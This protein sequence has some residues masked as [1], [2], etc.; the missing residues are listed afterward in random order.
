MNTPDQTVTY[1]ESTHKIRG[2]GEGRGTTINTAL[3]I[4]HTVEAYRMGINMP[5]GKDAAVIQQMPTVQ[6]VR[7]RQWARQG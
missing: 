4:S 7:D 6:R 5:Q 3:T 2:H 1:S